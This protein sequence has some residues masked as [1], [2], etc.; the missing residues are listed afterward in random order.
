VIAEN[1]RVR[2]NATFSLDTCWVQ[3]MPGPFLGATPVQWSEID[4]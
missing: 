2:G 4:R 1:I 3:N